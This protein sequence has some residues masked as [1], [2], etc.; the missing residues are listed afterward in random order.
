[1][2]DEELDKQVAKE[3]IEL[4][5]GFHHTKAVQVFEEGISTHWHQLYT[6]VKHS[7]EYTALIPNR[8]YTAYVISVLILSG[9]KTQWI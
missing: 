1:M 8:A 9:V 3:V 2:T 4:W 6:L 5:E 7:S